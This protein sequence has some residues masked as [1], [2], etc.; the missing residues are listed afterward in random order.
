MMVVWRRHTRALFGLLRLKS[1][2]I[3]LFEATP[4]AARQSLYL[5]LLIVPLRVFASFI[6]DRPF[7]ADPVVYSALR[8]LQ[9]VAAIT[10]P[11]PFIWIFC[12]AQGLRARFALFMTSYLWLAL[13]WAVFA[14]TLNGLTANTAFR[15]DTLKLTGTILFFISYAYSIYIAWLSLRCN[16]LVAIGVA[17]FAGLLATVTSDVSNI[18][19]FGSARPHIGE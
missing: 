15:V 16:I 9:V 14:A 6:A 19:L 1:G 12:R 13:F 8:S 7:M 18:Y 4:Q 11:L 3:D 2:A 17:A 10:L 5:L